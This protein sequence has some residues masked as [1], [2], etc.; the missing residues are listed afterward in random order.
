MALQFDPCQGAPERLALGWKPDN[1]VEYNSMRRRQLFGLCLRP[2]RGPL[3]FKVAYREVM[4][5]FLTNT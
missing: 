2:L 5:C 4:P 1:L 3:Q